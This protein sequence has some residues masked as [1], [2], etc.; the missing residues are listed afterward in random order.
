MSK[1]RQFANFFVTVESDEDV[2]GEDGPSSKP[3]KRVADLPEVHFEQEEE[4]DIEALERE[5]AA[6]RS[7]APSSTT[8]PAR[9]GAFSQSSTAR[10]RP[11]GTPRTAS[12]QGF[13]PLEFDEIYT[14]EGLPTELSSD[15]TVYT[16]EQ[17]LQ[18]PHL[19]NLP[20]ST[21]TASL[22]VALQARNVT[23]GEV[24]EDARR[25]D[26]AL[27][28]HD[29]TLMEALL[30]MEGEVVEKNQAVQDRINALL[31]EL[32]LEVETNNSQLSQAR[33]Q[34]DEWKSAKVAEEDRLFQTI[35][36]LVEQ[37]RPNPVS[38]DN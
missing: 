5:L 33:E 24:I 25:R 17:L 19:V 26:Q 4:F 32:R 3:Q 2:P 10:P 6:Q 29:A 14:N 13:Q 7:P 37:G 18:N 1:L 22:M 15:F 12:N 23:V 38:V 31:E 16:I 21:K 34:Y 36:H 9:V 11:S 27:D 30:S 35:R 28:E 8:P 20:E